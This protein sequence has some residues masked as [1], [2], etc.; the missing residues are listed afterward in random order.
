[1][2]GGS[3]REEAAA[4]DRLYAD[5]LA[6]GEQLPRLREVLLEHDPE[7]QVLLG[8]L[9]R[10]VP[11]K[12][13]EHLGSTPPWSDRPRVLARLV[14]NPRVPRSL[15]LRVVPT[16]YWRDL[17]EVAAAP[18]VAAGVRVRA[19]AS[20]KELLGDLRLGDRVSLA[21][22]ATPA[23]LVGLLSDAEP[24]VTEAGLINARLR[25]EDL[26][27]ALRQVDVRPALIQAVVASSRWS[28][29]YAVKLALVLQS[30]TPLG[31]ALAQVSSLVKR[32]L[33]RVVETRGLRP[34]I[35]AAA[36][37]VLERLAERP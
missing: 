29:S 31:I 37:A 25:E 28:A 26:L 22:V 32:D 15:A 11:V 7:E 18:Y 20:L 24:R 9:R 35:Q 4:I 30:K 1:M 10:A 17:A 27:V 6:A 12:L 13:L 3:E 2:L 19:E 34:L 14:L 5:L 8:V 33:V 21:K 23:V 16:L 36:A